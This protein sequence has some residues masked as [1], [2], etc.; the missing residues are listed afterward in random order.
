MKVIALRNSW[1]RPGLAA[2]LCAL[3]VAGCASKAKKAPTL[4]YEER[5]VNL[6]YDT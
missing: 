1:A 4:A 6:L 5:P 2:A 3:A